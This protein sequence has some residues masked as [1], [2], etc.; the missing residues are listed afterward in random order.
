MKRFQILLTQ[1]ALSAT[2]GAL[3]GY[4]YAR[5]NLPPELLATE[6]IVTG[7]YVLAGAAAGLVTLRL[8][9]LGK[10]MLDDYR[11]GS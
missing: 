3:I 6:K 7:G 1:S 4:S 5:F 9:I 10:R 2:A 8:A 11:Q